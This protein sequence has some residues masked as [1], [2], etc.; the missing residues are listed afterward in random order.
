[1][2]LVASEFQMDVLRDPARFQIV[3]AGRRVGKTYCAVLKLLSIVPDMKPGDDVVIVAKTY[4]Q[5]R[6]VWLAMLREVFPKEY[7]KNINLSSMVITLHND[8]N[9]HL[10]TGADNSSIDSIRGMSLSYACID[11][12]PFFRDPR[13]CWEDVIMPALADKRGGAMI[14]SS[15]NGRDYFYD[16]HTRGK[17]PEYPQWSS[18]H[19]DYTKAFNRENVAE[20]AEEAKRTVDALVFNREWLADF[21]TSGK[22][23]YYQF[24][25]GV[26]VST[27]DNFDEHETVRLG[28][29]FNI[30]NMSCIEWANRAGQAHILGE[31]VGAT[32][33]E[34]LCTLIKAKYPDKRI[35]AYPDPAGSARKT[36]AAVGVTDFSIIRA[37]GIEVLAKNRTQS[38]MD[39]VNNVNKMLKNAAGE[40]NLYIHPRCKR[41]IQSIDRLSWREDAN[42]AVYADEQYS[43]FPD[44]LRYPIDYCFG[45]NKTTLRRINVSGL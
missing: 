18:H 39:G 21:A 17:S 15:P 9:I 29:D 8:V 28:I 19:A 12:F 35:I 10:R 36:S 34:E 14:V 45:I 1:M 16:L 6:S 43:H 5:V 11:E 2:E 38:I 20:L 13:Y 7:I 23:V 32:N 33:T 42:T 22:T 24:D 41:L 44:A 26:N 30:A 40:S 4:T 31:I 37:A 25:H 27:V 3:A